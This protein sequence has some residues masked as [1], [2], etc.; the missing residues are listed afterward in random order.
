M[1]LYRPTWF[2]IDLDAAAENLRTARRLV[3]PE[4]KLFAV[5][6]AG[7][8]GFGSAEMG[9]VFA[10]NGADALAVADLSDG[11]RLRR[12]GLTLPILVYPNALPDVAADV[13]A[14]RLTPTL[15][16][17][18]GVRAYEAAAG[19]PEHVPPVDVF[20][21]VDV[22]LERLGVPAD[23]AVKLLLD[24][25]NRPRLRLAG[26]CTHLHVPDAAD[27]AYVDW[28]F[29]RFTAVLDALVAHGVEVPVRLAASS[30]L[31]LGYPDT[32]LNAVD[33]GRML[34]GI[35]REDRGGPV[36]L[37]PV[38]AALK[39]RLIE[40]KDVT[41][42]ER[43]ATTAPFP[44]PHPMRLGVIPIGAGDGFNHLHV[45]RV[46]VRGRRAPILSGPSLEH[47][48]VDLTAVPDA[49][50]GDEVVLIGRQGG[51]QI[52]LDEVADR[53]G[54]DPLH[55]ALAVGPRVARVY[56]RDGGPPIV[57]AGASARPAPATAEPA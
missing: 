7:G 8:Y 14:A 38:F 56:V 4:R 13:V 21:K 6:K 20:V 46:L 33:P 27:G 49:A 22:G 12:L 3:G 32:Y 18:D 28:Q 1:R 44:I 30:P 19:V 45:G 29:K 39:S 47:T 42:R 34:Y 43:F 17:L 23:Q 52:T 15:T 54:L 16:D 37:R 57:D 41:P 36:S 40:V 25:R 35:D 10:E 5:V 2:E 53:H 9:R 11:V 50:V 31:V 51:E 48:R 24:V 55:V 26:V